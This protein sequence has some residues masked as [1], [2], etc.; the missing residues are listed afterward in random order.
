MIRNFDELIY[1]LNECE[2]YIDNVLEG[3]KDVDAEVG[4]QMN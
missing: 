4:R 3:K 1:N 2:K